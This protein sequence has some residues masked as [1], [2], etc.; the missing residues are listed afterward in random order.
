MSMKLLLFI[1]F[2][3]FTQIALGSVRCPDPIHG[4]KET[5]HSWKLYG[6][7]GHKFYAVSQ[8]KGFKIKEVIIFLDAGNKN[9]G[10]SIPMKFTVQGGKAEGEFDISGNWESVEIVAYYGEGICD[11]KIAVSVSM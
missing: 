5:L 11:P 2:L 10:A 9:P 4:S 1:I 7:L 3:T 8:Y 6:G